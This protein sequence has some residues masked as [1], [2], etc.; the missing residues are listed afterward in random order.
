MPTYFITKGT[1][2]RSSAV[3][4]LENDTWRSISPEGEISRSH[5]GALPEFLSNQVVEMDPAEASR[6]IDARAAVIRQQQAESDRVAREAAA[7]FRCSRAII[8]SVLVILL[9][10]GVGLVV[11][12]CGIGPL[13]VQE[14]D[15]VSAAVTVGYEP[16]VVYRRSDRPSPCERNWPDS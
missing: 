12:Y 4:V 15:L 9:L 2:P 3:Y 14:K 8:I 16:R 6:L 1:D 10:T 7:R 11:G 13:H 5:D